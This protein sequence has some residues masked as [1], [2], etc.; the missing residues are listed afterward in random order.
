MSNKTQLAT[1]NT[2]LASLINTL[3]GKAK[4]EDVFET[5]EWTITLMD[6]TTVTKVVYVD[7]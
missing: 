1:N 2:Q 7:D 3:Q 4:P 5:E 6:G